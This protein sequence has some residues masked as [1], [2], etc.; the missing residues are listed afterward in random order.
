MDDLIVI[1]IALFISMYIVYFLVNKYASNSPYAIIE[2]LEN[3]STLNATNGEAGSAS[4]Y[5]ETIKANFIKLQDELLITKYRKDY[6]KTVINME[7][8]VNMLMVKQVLNMDVN[9]SDAKKNMEA[10]NNLNTLKLSKD[11][12]NDVM[13]FIDKQ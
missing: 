12:L 10:F 1:I 6:E 7:D 11:A 13:K 5:A 2:G 8:Y 3:I 4:T 9:S